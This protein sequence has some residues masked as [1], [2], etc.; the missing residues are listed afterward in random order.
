MGVGKG[1]DFGNAKGN[2]LDAISNLLAAASLIPG[3]IPL[4]IWHQ[5]RLI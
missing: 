3:L 4:R 5:Y 1:G 2:A